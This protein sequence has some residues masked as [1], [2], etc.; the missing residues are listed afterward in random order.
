MYCVQLPRADT[1]V[2]LLH[3]RPL[4][5]NAYLPPHHHFSQHTRN[6]GRRGGKEESEESG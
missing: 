4:A 5:T 6:S 1:Q 2:R 3:G